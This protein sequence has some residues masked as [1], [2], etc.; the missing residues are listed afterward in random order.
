MAQQDKNTPQAAHHHPPEG[1]IAWFFHEFGTVVFFG[2]LF[3]MMVVLPLALIPANQ[4]R[5][6]S[7]QMVDLIRD[8]ILAPWALGI[9]AA[10]IGTFCV[11]FWATRAIGLYM[12]GL[13]VLA[14]GIVFVTYPEA[15]TRFY[16]QWVFVLLIIDVLVANFGFPQKTQ[17]KK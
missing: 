17:P 1:T 10:F 14:F 2:S 13:I 12:L 16:L 15:Y 6:I 8:V 4:S 7:P 9:I 11:T 5:L 3:V